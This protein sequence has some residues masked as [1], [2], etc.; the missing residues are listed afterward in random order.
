MRTPHLLFF[1]APCIL[2][3]SAPTIFAQPIDSLRTVMLTDSS[4]RTFS[5]YIMGGA[6]P[7]AS[8]ALN[9]FA[10]SNGFSGEAFSPDLLG[11]N[12]TLTEGIQLTLNHLVRLHIPSR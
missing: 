11:G 6:S 2:F 3:C 4:N 9:S 7:A 8:K 12:F 5:L 10:A 1:V